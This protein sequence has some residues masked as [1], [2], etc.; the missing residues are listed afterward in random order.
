MASLEGVLNGTVELIEI[1]GYIKLPQRIGGGI[2][3]EEVALAR[4][5]YHFECRTQNSDSG[6][7][8]PKDPEVRRSR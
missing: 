8:T 3:S 2:V 5:R 1:P 7:H 4:L 6:S